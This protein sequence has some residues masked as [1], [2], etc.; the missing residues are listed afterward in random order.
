[1]KTTQ[2]TYSITWCRLSVF[3]N[4]RYQSGGG[5]SN[6]VFTLWPSWVWQ[7]V[8]HWRYPDPMDDL[9][10]WLRKYP[11]TDRDG[12][13]TLKMAINRWCAYCEPGNLIRLNRTL[14]K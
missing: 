3:R 5:A 11:H 10:K 2:T 9:A 1:M 8:R 4:E 7:H 14:V 12:Y 6:R 13:C